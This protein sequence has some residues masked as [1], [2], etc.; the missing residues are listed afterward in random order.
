ME[1]IGFKQEALWR[2]SVHQNKNDHKFYWTLHKQYG[3]KLFKDFFRL[4]KINHIN[5]NNIGKPWPHPDKQRSL[6]TLGLLS[7]AA[8]KNLANLANH[9][10]IGLKPKDWYERHPEIEFI[11]YQ[12]TS[13]DIEEYEKRFD[14]SITKP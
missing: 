14:E 7:L 9:H 13:Q 11:E 8:N 2:K 6:V 4:I 3:T 1:R 5:L 12:I 10:N